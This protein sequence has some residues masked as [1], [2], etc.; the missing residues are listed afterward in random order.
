MGKWASQLGGGNN[1]PVVM[2]DVFNFYKSTNIPVFVIFISDGGVGYDDQIKNLLIQYSKFPIFWQFVGIGGGNYGIL[3][4]LDTL[5]DRYVDNCNFFSLDN[6]KSVSDTQ[7]YDLLL[8]E[9]PSWLNNPK[10]KKMI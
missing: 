6:I 2:Q 5:K 7:L 10:V 9:L 4:Q 3:Q 1:E 8:N